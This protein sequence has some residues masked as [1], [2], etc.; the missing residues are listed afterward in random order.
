[1]AKDLAKGIGHMRQNGILA[2]FAAEMKGGETEASNQ[3][4]LG[5]RPGAYR[6][7]HL[8]RSLSDTR[9]H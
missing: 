7:D 8:V 5:N 3:Q 1:M 6:H 4:V 2:D 9:L